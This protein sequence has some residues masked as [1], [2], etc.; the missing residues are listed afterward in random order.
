MLVESEGYIYIYIFK[1]TVSLK[2]KVSSPEVVG[3]KNIF[4]PKVFFH[5]DLPW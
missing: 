2:N 5:G 4:P 1:E 3:K